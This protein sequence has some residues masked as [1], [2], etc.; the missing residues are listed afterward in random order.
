[1]QLAGVATLMP[2]LKKAAEAPKNEKIWELSDAAYRLYDAAMH[3]AAEHLTDGHV[4]A[5]RIGT[6]KP[7][8]ATPAQISELVSGRLWHRLPGLSCK[9]CL[10]L[11]EQHNAAP[12]P[13]SGFVVH[14]FLQYNPSKTEW[15]ARQQ[16]TVTLAHAGGAARAAQAAREGGRFTSRT[17]GET[18]SRDTSRAAGE[19]GDFHQPAHQP[20]AGENAPAAPAV[21]PAVSPAPYSVLRSSEYEVRGPD[22]E[23]PEIPDAPETGDPRGTDRKAILATRTR[24]ELR[25]IGHAVDEVLARARAGVGT[26]VVRDSGAT[27]SRPNF[28]TERPT[29][30]R[31][32]AAVQR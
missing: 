21:S 23:D 3:Y 17:A 24:P 25:P 15:E 7:K 2:W 22:A 6:L 28:S 4:P 27:R 11:R 20:A 18:T 32:R 12:L 19:N 9:S 31:G 30:P 29:Q 26:W 13:R 1:V 10:A 14:D 16:R 8:A 5:S